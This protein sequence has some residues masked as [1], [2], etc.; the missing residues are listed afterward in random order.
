MQLERSAYQSG[1]E[2]ELLTVRFSDS[3]TDAFDR[4]V[5]KNPKSAWHNLA[6]ETAKR[7]NI[8]MQI[9]DLEDGSLAAAFLTSKDCN[10]LIAAMQPDWKERLLDG[11]GYEVWIYSI[12]FHE[13]REALDRSIEKLSE[14]YELD[15]SDFEEMIEDNLRSIANMDLPERD[16]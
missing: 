16:F 15:P 12:A 10:R 8:D 7:L 3:V 4:G 6:T 9:R 14:E 5:I 13:N 2:P 1:S 11:L